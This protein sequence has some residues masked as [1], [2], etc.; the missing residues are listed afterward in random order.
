M[1]HDHHHHGDSLRDYFTEQLLNIL[2]VGAF[3]F[4]ALM[5]YSNGMAR[6]ILSEQFLTPLMLGGVG[7]LV[8][9]ALRAVTVWRE[10]GEMRAHAAAHDHHHHDHGHAHGHGHDHHHEHGPN[11][12]HSH[13]HEHHAL[14]HHEGHTDADHGHSHDLSWTIA[15]VLVLFFPIALYFLGLPSRELA[16]ALAENRVGTDAEMATLTQEEMAERAMGAEQVGAETREADGRVVRIL[17][18]KQP[19][20]L[21]E[22]TLPD[23]TKKY[24]PHVVLKDPIVMSFKDLNDAAGDDG[25]REGLEGET[26]VI[27]GRMNRVTDKQFTLYRM[28]MTCCSADMVPLKV[29]MVAPQALAGY[30]NGEWVKV[31]GRLEFHQVTEGK[32][33]HFVP[34]IRVPATSEQFIKKVPAESEN[35]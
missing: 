29:R 16:A 20:E 24:E 21:K 19:P 7:V 17:R 2:V 33:T 5:M 25:K 23:G 27:V 26:V 28:K 6:L 31:T 4:V 30:Q 10:A 8:V 11:C 12:D 14:H 34:V 35:E 22:T 15:R 32:V 3:G 18:P 9:V 13:D 1:A